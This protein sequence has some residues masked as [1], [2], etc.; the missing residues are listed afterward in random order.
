MTCVGVGTGGM[1]RIG[2]GEDAGTA[3]GA[4]ETG[5]VTVLVIT[6]LL[7]TTTGAGASPAGWPA[8]PV[9][10]PGRA[11]A[12]P[13]PSLPPAPPAPEAAVAPA[14]GVPNAQP[15]TTAK[16]NPIAT[17]PMKTDLGD[18]RTCRTSPESGKSYGFR[19]YQP[20]KM[21]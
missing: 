11:G 2:G 10:D 12:T 13:R 3:T 20:V 4:A 19:T 21:P 18:K 8:Y 17:T 1:V 9:D 5:T 16:G 6:V 7:T 14:T 15:T